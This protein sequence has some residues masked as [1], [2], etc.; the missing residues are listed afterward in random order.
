MTHLVVVNG[1]IASGKT[2]TAQGLATWVRD[3]GF[4][5]AAIEMDELIQIA[6]GTDWTRPWT[7]T[8]WRLARSLA[9]AL[10][11]RLCEEDTTLVALSGQFFD[12]QERFALTDA[13]ASRPDI[14][15]FTLQTSLDETLRRCA[16][17]NRRVLTKDAEFVS[18]IYSGLNW[19]ALPRDEVILSTEKLSL[20]EI[21]EVIVAEVGLGR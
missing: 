18:R 19:A 8:D 13:L 10:I 15:F 14:H 5:A 1:P 9:C 17:D 11:D 20:N 16:D 21:V 12:P 7:V 2:T 3:H 6:R 4:R